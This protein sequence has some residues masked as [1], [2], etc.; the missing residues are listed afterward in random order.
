MEPKQGA[1]KLQKFSLFP[2]WGGA[3]HWDPSSPLSRGGWGASQQ[4]GNWGWCSPPAACAAHL[5]SRGMMMKLTLL[6]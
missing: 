2:A 3:V 5:V 4:R 6:I 1:L